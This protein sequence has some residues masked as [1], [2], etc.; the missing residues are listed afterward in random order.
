MAGL[1]LALL[2]C[3]AYAPV[4]RA[5]FIWDDEA[6]TG[7]PA[8]GKPGGIFEIWSKPTNNPNE[9]HYWPL[10]YSSFWLERRLWGPGPLGYHLDN[11]LLHA[12]NTLLLWRLLRRLG[13]RG[14][15]LGAALFGVHPIHAESVAWVIERKDVL[16][17]CFCLLALLGWMEWLERRKGSGL[18]LAFVLLTAA[19]LSKS[20]AVSLPATMGILAWWRV[21]RWRRGDVAALAGLAALTAGLTAFD[22][23]VVRLME[24]PVDVGLAS[25]WDRLALAGRNAWI[26]AGRCLWPTRLASVYPLNIV[27]ATRPGAW[28]GLAGVAV[29]LAASIALRRRLGRG[30]LAGLLMYG[31]T[32]A[33]VSGLVAFSYMYY[34][35]TADRFAY[36]PS[37]VLLAGVA[38]LAAL[39]L[40]RLAGGRRWPAWVAGAAL[41]APLAALC[42]RQAGYYQNPIVLF[43]RNVDLY[44]DSWGARQMLGNALMKQGKPKEALVEI[45]EA[46]RMAP[47]AKKCQFYVR[48]HLGITLADLGQWDEALA[49]TNMALTLMP[50]QDEALINRARIYM[51]TRRLDKA[52]A[53][54]S[55]ELARQPND[56]YSL[57][58]LGNVRRKQGKLDVACELF[59]R[60][61]AVDAGNADLR[62]NLGAGLAQ[63]GDVA[64]A[65]VQ[66]QEALRLNPAMTAAAARLAALSKEKR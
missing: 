19:M 43:R 51:E 31:A 48:S 7:Y 36:A 14:A 15:W 37:M 25:P 9:S 65:I 55:K 30:Q 42:W 18:A 29:L 56:P 3:A 23:R 16:S 20:M 17:G 57:S 2:A 32:L 1:A 62:F 8:I 63:K 60:A 33:P 49:Q 28:M 52:A 4:L 13:L 44:P 40:E 5:G 10:T 6:M 64:G 61:V 50:D 54:F 22:L 41:L 12:A 46:L 45:R 38:E 66:F 35:L 26:Y 27:H 58:C 47:S 59:A 21:G 11:V 53:D 34:S 39:G 24:T